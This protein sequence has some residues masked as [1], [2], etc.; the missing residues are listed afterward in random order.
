[1][2][3]S[4]FLLACVTCLC[5]DAQAELGAASI[6]VNGRASIRATSPLP[7][8]KPALYTIQKVI[9]LDDIEIHEYA[10]LNGLVF[11]LRWRGETKPAMPQLLG[12]FALRYAIAVNQPL[13][14]RRPVSINDADLVIQTGGRMN[15]FFG[16]AFLPRLAPQGVQLSEIH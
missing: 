14:A 11:G 13:A 7:S 15:D 2:K 9:T 8:P 10:N 1:M 4:S 16:V 12:R 3:F 6:S 5:F